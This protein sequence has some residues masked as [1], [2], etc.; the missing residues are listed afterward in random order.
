[1]ILLFSFWGSVAFTQSECNCKPSPGATIN[2]QHFK[3]KLTKKNHIFANRTWT[4]PWT[5][6]TNKLSIVQYIAKSSNIVIFS[7]G[8]WFWQRTMTTRKS[9][10]P[11]RTSQQ[12]KKN[13]HSFNTNASKWNSRIKLRQQQHWNHQRKIAYKFW[14]VIIHCH[15]IASWRIFKRLLFRWQH[16]FIG[17]NQVHWG[18]GGIFL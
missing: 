13:R 2:Q 16:K 8:T 17:S 7:S 4:Q 5:H 18:C 6:W 1:M 12:R 14:A 15:W 11:N 3:W 10:A 9:N